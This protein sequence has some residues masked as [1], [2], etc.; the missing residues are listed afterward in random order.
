MKKRI[1]A[2]ALALT[3]C[4][5]FSFPA[6]SVDNPCFVVV[7]Y[8]VLPIS[9]ANN[10]ITSGG[11]LYL[12]V[13]VFENNIPAMYTS[14]S[15]ETRYQTLFIKDK[16][17]TFNLA[18]NVAFDSAQT[19][20][21]K[22][23][24]R[25]GRIYVPVVF[26]CE[27]FGYSVTGGLSTKYAPLLRIQTGTPQNNELFLSAAA[28]RIDTVWSEYQASLVTPPPSSGSPAPSPSPTPKPVRTAYLT[29]DDGPGALTNQLLD[30]LD[31]YNIKA[32][33]FFLGTNIHKNEDAVRRAL[34]SGHAVGLHSYSHR[35][36]LFYTSP[37]AMLDELK[38]T[39]D[40]LDRVAFY[41]T[42]LVRVPYGSNPDMRPELLEAMAQG[43]YRMWDWN[44]DPQDSLGSK[45]ASVVTIK[46]INDV[47]ALWDTYR[48]DPIILLHELS[49]SL[50]ALPSILDYL[51]A[52][53]YVFKTLSDTQMPYNY[54]G[55]IK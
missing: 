9:D 6:K 22:A 4:F 53:G 16:T 46:T 48:K 54:K 29:F 13:H 51:L 21:A 35:K 50:E 27:Y 18:Q 2:A 7:N 8:S 43:G 14:Y 39:N 5:C 24:E 44:I 19:Y 52:E 49:H 26:T 45:T 38:R 32:T 47:K 30:V 55:L 31:Q 3:L 34:G 10:P 25:D 36:E 42:R 37:A 17:L 33:F 20:S 1:L 28:S 23:I 12:P 41:R 11:T 15:P 40:E